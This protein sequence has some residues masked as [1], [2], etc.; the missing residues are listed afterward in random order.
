MSAEG[1]WGWGCRQLTIEHTV[2]VLSS[3]NP[4]APGIDKLLSLGETIFVL[5]VEI[6]IPS[7]SSAGGTERPPFCAGAL[8]ACCLIPV[9]GSVQL[10]Y[11]FQNA[12]F[13]NE[14][15]IFKIYLFVQFTFWYQ[16]PHSSLPFPFEKGNPLWVSFPPTWHIMSPQEGVGIFSPT[17]AKQGGTVRE[18]GSTGR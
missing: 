6:N 11:F 16:S 5:L 1:S 7:N 12:Y 14:R 17:E 10:S 8:G 9:R 13:L 18:T 3:L 4:E 15:F 2:D